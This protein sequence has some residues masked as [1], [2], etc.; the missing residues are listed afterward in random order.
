MTTAYD[1]AAAFTALHRPGTPLLLPNAWDPLSARIVE[2]AGAPA[3]ATTSAGVAWALGAADGDHID[4]D[5]MLALTAR[6]VAAVRVPVT[7]DIESGFGAT[8][9]EVG[10]T[11]GGVLAA[12]AAGA[13]I[14][15]VHPGDP[16]ALRDPKEQAER[17][18]AARSAADAA[19]V[20]FYVNARIDTY[21]RAVG[22]PDSRFAD[23]VA[24]AQAYLQAG[25]SG[26]FVPGVVD[27]PTVT[28]LAA[29]IDGPLNVLAGP[30]APPVAELA[31]AGVARVSLGSSVAAAAYAVAQRAA[32]EL[33]EQGTYTAVEGGLAYGDLNAL[34]S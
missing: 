7:A 2:A 33:F 12:G 34:M 20:P 23:T 11:A 31:A 10:V 17:L 9:A 21:L 1:T 5:S 27:A 26:V 6:V 15:D 25:A 4:R 16:A 28:R 8:P 22:D 32:N 18:A 3:V 29:E 30:G 14:E 13:N 24:R 19:G